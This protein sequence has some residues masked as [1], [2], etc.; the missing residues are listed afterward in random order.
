M[1]AEKEITHKNMLI[2]CYGP[3]THSNELPEIWH[4]VPSLL[5]CNKKV[6]ILNLKK[7]DASVGGSE[8]PTFCCD[9][10]K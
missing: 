3:L 6:R 5:K 4:R 7:G 9:E 8:R 10:L 2:V 1:V